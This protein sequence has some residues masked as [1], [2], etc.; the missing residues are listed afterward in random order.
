MTTDHPFFNIQ[1]TSNIL[2]IQAKNLANLMIVQD[3]PTITDTAYGVI[4]DL[5]EILQKKE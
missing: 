2:Q 5:L 1:G 4:N 3:K